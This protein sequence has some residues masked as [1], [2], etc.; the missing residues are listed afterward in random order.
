MNGKQDVPISRVTEIIP[1]QLLL[2]RIN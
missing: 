2:F 1:I